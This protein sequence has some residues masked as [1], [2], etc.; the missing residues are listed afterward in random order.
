MVAARIQGWTFLLACM[1]LTAGCRSESR[2]IRSELAGGWTI[3]EGKA[4]SI[5]HDSLIEQEEEI[6]L[7]PGRPNELITVIRRDGSFDLSHSVFALAGPEI[8]RLRKTGDCIRAVSPTG[9][10]IGR[11]EVVNSRYKPRSSKMTLRVF[12]DTRPIE[13]NTFE[14]EMNSASRVDYRH[15]KVDPQVT[16][17]LVAR[18]TRLQGA[19]PWE[20]A[21]TVSVGTPTNLV[22]CID[23]GGQIIYSV[24]FSPDARSVACGGQ[25]GTVQVFDVESGRATGLL[26]GP[27]AAVTSVAFSHDGRFL[28]SGS[29]TNYDG[30]EPLGEFVRL[31][32]LAAGKEVRRFKVPAMIKEVAFS[33]DDQLVIAGGDCKHDIMKDLHEVAWVW[34]VDSGRTLCPLLHEKLTVE[35]LAIA[36]DSRI[37]VGIT[38]SSTLLG[39]DQI[40]TWDTRSGERLTSFGSRDGQF[41]RHVSFS[42]DGTRI[43]TSGQD[44][45]EWDINGGRP[46]REIEFDGVSA[47]RAVYVPGDHRVLTLSLP[48]VIQLWDVEKPRMIESFKDP[49]S[50]AASYLDI[51]VSRDGKLAASAGTDGKIRLWRLPDLAD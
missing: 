34:E 33:H 22:R 8:D 14:A 49:N 7:P 9:S 51:D 15:T 41:L 2:Q 20:R 48:D 16:Q 10:E 44:V 25:D 13:V 6:F 4:T 17:I 1:I 30:F 18:L 45:I 23:A 36:P 42:Q 3:V 31:W 29:E 39:G 21:K 38:E 28:V 26:V 11:I 43:L 27:S 32:D 5:S 19:L 50:D 40:H 46:L 24:A 35:S 47:D 12:R 37:I